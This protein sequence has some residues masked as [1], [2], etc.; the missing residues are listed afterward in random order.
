MTQIASDKLAK[1][2][3]LDRG[4]HDRI[5]DGL[6]DALGLDDHRERVRAVGTHR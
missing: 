6:G 2:L 3:G 1:S 5:V 4:D